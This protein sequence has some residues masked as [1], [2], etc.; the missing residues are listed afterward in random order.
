MKTALIIIGFDGFQDTEFQ[1][2]YTALQ[3]SGV[4]VQIASQKVGIATGKY[5]AQQEVDIDL[6]QAAKKSYDAV[7]FIGGPGATVFQEDQLAHQIAKTTQDQGQILAAICIAP[8]IL[9]KAGV[10]KDKRATVWNKDGETSDLIESYGAKYVDKDLVVD[11]KLIT[12]SGPE[13][14]ERFAQEIVNQIFV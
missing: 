2:P 3:E 7:I 11:G 6:T 10:L 4:E 9:A 8:T 1:V 12:A 13:A 5:G 14:A